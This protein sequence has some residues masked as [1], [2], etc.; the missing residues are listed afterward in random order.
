MGRTRRFTKHNID[1]AVRL[2]G[3]ARVM[4]T[5]RL[6]GWSLAQSSHLWEIH[7]AGAGVSGT[8][9]PYAS[10]ILRRRL[11]SYPGP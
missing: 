6:G 1:G 3:V 2:V 10:L 8:S 9:M 7:E 4:Y 11:S 5:M